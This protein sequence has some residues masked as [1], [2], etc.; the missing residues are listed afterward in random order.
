VEER[1]IKVTINQR[2][3][4]VI[5]RVVRAVERCW[6]RW[7]QELNIA[8][9]RLD[10]QGGVC[11]PAGLVPSLAQELGRDGYEVAVQDE[12]EHNLGPDKDTIEQS[13]GPDRRYLEALRSNPQGV[14]EV[15][16]DKDLISKIALLG[17]LY[18]GAR[19]IVAVPTRKLA[20]K[21]RG[22]L[23]K[24]SGTTVG[25]V[26]AKT[27]RPGKHICVC[28]YRSLA[29][30]PRRE[31][32]ILAVM[33]AERAPDRV[34][35][36]LDS[37]QLFERVY[38][39]VHAGVTLDEVAALK[40]KGLAGEVIHATGGTTNRA[41]V[42]V[43]KSPPL[44]EKVKGRGVQ[45]K[46]RMYWQNRGRN[47]LVAKVALAFAK[48]LDSGETRGITRANAAPFRRSWRKQRALGAT[49]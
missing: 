20:W 33:E 48:K 31:E 29:K 34:G 35:A 49:A 19:V 42:L 14:V 23:Q 36:Y 32:S 15:G 6:V 22:A 8:G 39:L 4:A 10:K 44:A 9:V 1:T 40:L 13:E 30:L 45:R 46:R 18:P 27:R 41:R 21:V 12:R 38:G 2:H 5:D 26:T 47:R 17:Q 43:V 16:G 3:D 28:T 25:L 37:E 7:K 11:I 24:E